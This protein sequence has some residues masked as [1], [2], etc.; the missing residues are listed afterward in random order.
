MPCFGAQ[1]KAYDTAVAPG[2]ICFSLCV[3]M[4]LSYK[5]SAC[6]HWLLNMTDSPTT[7]GPISD[8]VTNSVRVEVLSRH[9]PEN[10][11][12]HQGEWVFQYTVRITNQGSE[13]VQ[14]LS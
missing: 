10:S 4:A 13:T 1:A 7:L 8:A 12:P 3:T 6:Y 14:L 9:S 11:R 5:K 2:S